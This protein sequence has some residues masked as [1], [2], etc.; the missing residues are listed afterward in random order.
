ML[1][2]LTTNFDN[3]NAII[4]ITHSFTSTPM[5]V[6][7]STN[8]VP[9]NPQKYTVDNLAKDLEKIRYLECN[10]QELLKTVIMK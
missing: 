1:N 6:I 3:K 5:S 7:L 2:F 9:T 10:R 4:R 8:V